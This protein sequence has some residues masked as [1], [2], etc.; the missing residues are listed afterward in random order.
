MKYSN[1]RIQSRKEMA[2]ATVDCTVGIW[3]FK[4]TRTALLYKPHFSS[5]WRD[6]ETGDFVPEVTRLAEAA[7]A[8]ALY[9]AAERASA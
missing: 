1:M 9:R 2:F 7:E 4:S 5:Y 6:I 8:M 3:P